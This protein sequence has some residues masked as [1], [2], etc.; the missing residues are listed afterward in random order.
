MIERI[1]LKNASIKYWIE[2]LPFLPE[3]PY[4][5]DTSFFNVGNEE[6]D[7]KTIKFAIELYLHKNSGNYGLLGFEYTPNSGGCLELIIHYVKENS[8]Q[9]ESQLTQYNDYKYCGLPEENIKIIK[10]TF[11]KFLSQKEGFSGGMF[12]INV[13]ANCE[14]GSSPLLYSIIL[15]MLLKID[16]RYDTIFDFAFWKSQHFAIYLEELG[17]K[18]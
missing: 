16:F 3:Y 4:E 2:E 17:I 9:Y 14:V 11:A 6:T 18:L 15:E 12:K 5:V 10:D 13:S 7:C 1:E 8:V